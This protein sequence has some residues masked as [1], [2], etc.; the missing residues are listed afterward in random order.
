M[1]VAALRKKVSTQVILRK[2]P[3]TAL[4]VNA[5]AE[6]NAKKKSFYFYSRINNLGIEF[7][8]SGI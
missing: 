5:R 3:R 4:R 6:F 1:L 8:Y 7:E 2:V